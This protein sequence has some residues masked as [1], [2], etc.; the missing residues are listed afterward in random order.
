MPLLFGVG[1]SGQHVALA[2]ARLCQLGALPTTDVVIIDADDDSELTRALTS[3]GGTSA[4][5]RGHPLQSLR[6]FAPLPR[7][8]GDEVRFRGLFDLEADPAHAELFEAFFDPASAAVPVHQ[9]MYGNPAVGATVLAHVAGDELDAVLERATRTDSVAVAGSFVG[10]TGAG[11]VHQL[12]RRL[13]AMGLSE[14]TYLAALLPWHEPEGAVSAELPL[15]EASMNKNMRFG[16]DYLYHHSRLHMQSGCLL[17]IPSNRQSR[18]PPARVIVGK[19]HEY[20]HL[21]H[22]HAAYFLF[23]AG[24]TSVTVDQRH[25]ISGFV[26][27]P[28]RPRWLL[29]QRWQGGRSLQWYLLRARAARA[30]LGHL[31]QGRVRDEVRASFNLLFGTSKDLYNRALVETIKANAPK[32]LSPKDLCDLVMDQLWEELHRVD[33]SLEWAR[34]LWSAL[35]GSPAVAELELNP[36]AAIRAA[37]LAPLLPEAGEAQGPAAIAAWFAE[38]LQQMAA[39]QIGEER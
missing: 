10:G 33:Y 14:R 25:E 20:P 5:G 16:A 11:V 24:E 3:F 27:D 37:R 13:D 8:V 18:F 4:P 28:E 36:T 15:S 22:A 29:E 32:G 34:V 21:L 6:V 9:G 39:A 7:S 38:G 12:L 30:M 1:G 26:Y 31:C 23:Q 35:P 17:G 2:T 19:N